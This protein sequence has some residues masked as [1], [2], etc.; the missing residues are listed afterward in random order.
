M[1]LLFF[2]TS[3]FAVPALLALVRAGFPIGAVVTQPDKP[4]ERGLALRASPVKIKALELGLRVLEPSTLKKPEAEISLREIGAEIAVVAAYGKIVPQNILDIFPK[5]VLNIHPSL[6]PKYRGPSPIQS[7]ILNGDEETGVTIMLLDA[8]MDHGAIL[9]QERLRIKDY[10]LRGEL[11]IRLAG[12]GAQMLVQ[13]LPQWLE[14]KIQPREQDH[15][16]ATICKMVE[17]EDGKIDWNKPAVVI[18]RMVRAYEGW[19]G[20]WTSWEGKRLKILKARVLHEAIG[21]ANNSTQGFIWKTEQCEFA[22]NCHPGSLVLE[23]VQLE[24]KKPSAGKSFLLGYPR[25][26]GAVM[27]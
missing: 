3:D 10:E 8:E 13:V 14:G 11:E 7:A 5:G 4:A 18:E 1:S 16:E 20:T 9:A 25:I 26:F 17:K 23:E 21:C 19:P 6:L 22:I 24:G 2:G 15:E 12:L 27:T